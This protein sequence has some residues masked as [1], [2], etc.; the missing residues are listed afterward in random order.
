MV[1]LEDISVYIACLHN[2]VVKYIAT[3]PIMDLCLAVEQKPEMHLFRRWW[4][5]PALDIMGV[6]AGQVAAE[7]GGGGIG[8]RGIVG[9]GRM[10]GG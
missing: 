9:S 7:G 6:R 2:M 4:Y 5:Q 8:G 1:V 10:M 3:R